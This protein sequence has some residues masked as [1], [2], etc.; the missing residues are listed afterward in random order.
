MFSPINQRRK[1]D[2]KEMKD[3]PGQYL[4]VPSGNGL[5]HLGF[6]HFFT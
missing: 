2:K 6:K 1:R 3:T 4:V 5:L